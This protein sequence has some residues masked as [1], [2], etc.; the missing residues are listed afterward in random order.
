[1]RMRHIVMWSVRLY[2]MFSHFF[3]NG[4]IFE[5]KVLLKVK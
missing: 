2:N 1:M 3:I 5:K 4:T